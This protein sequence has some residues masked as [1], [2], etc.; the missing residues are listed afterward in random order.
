ML[1]S[2]PDANAVGE[3]VELDY[4]RRPSPL[5]RWRK[6]LLLLS[7]L[8]GVAAA[9]G[10]IG[11]AVAGFPQPR[12][13][14]AGGPVSTAHAQFYDQCEF[15]HTERFAT[16]DRL[17]R[18]DEGRRSI[19]NATC[20]GKCHDGPPHHDTALGT[21]DCVGCHREHRGQP[22][23]AT[24]ADVYCTGCHADLQTRSGET[25]FDR[26]VRAFPN[27]HPEFGRHRGKPL[28]DPGT[29][30]FNHQAHLKPGLL[31]P[32]RKPLDKPLD[33]SA[34]HRPDP[35][36][37]Y[38]LP[39]RYEE[40]CKSCHPLPV[41]LSGTWADKGLQEAAEQLRRESAPHP[42]KGQTAADVRN[43]LR[44]RLLAFARLPGVLAQAK[45]EPPAVEMPGWQR[46][47]RVLDK[48]LKWVNAQ[49]HDIEG[50]LFDHTGGCA[51]CH[52]ETTRA[53]RRPDGLPGYALPNLTDRWFPHSRFAHETHRLLGCL[54]CHE[55]TAISTESSD[56]LLPGRALCQQCHKPGGGA[57]MDCV[58]CHLYHDRSK[59]RG[60]NGQL[61]I[62]DCIRHSP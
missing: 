37:H 29:I 56:V 14:Y 15:C 40:H 24:V 59:D 20:A 13:V 17:W 43:A 48:E 61:T 60:L 6:Y 11:W 57:R 7:W 36:G 3:W 33:C 50:T 30:K 34:C 32:D 19:P 8:G 58:E 18:H 39:I 52:E 38:M 9:V 41:Q 55:R 2:R 62:K 23:L 27:D 4:V 46:A 47:P 22:L 42:H 25:L 31:G 1:L 5:V 45:E 10:L 44:G 49:L 53:D 28:T 35:A 12:T 51:Y 21:L 54:A 16:W 26:H